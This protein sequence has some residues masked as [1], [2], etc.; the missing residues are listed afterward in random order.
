MKVITICVCALFIIFGLGC[1]AV[2]TKAQETLYNCTVLTVDMDG[3]KTYRTGKYEQGQLETIVEHGG[4]MLGAHVE[5]LQK[6][7]SNDYVSPILKQEE[8]FSGAV[9]CKKI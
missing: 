4:G 1:Y 8:A 3:N 5:M 9:A 7:D 6:N 2:S